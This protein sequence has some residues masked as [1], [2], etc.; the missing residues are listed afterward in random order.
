LATIGWV[1]L[2]LVLNQPSRAVVFSLLYL[3]EKMNITDKEVQSVIEV[4]Y[5]FLLMKA[6]RLMLALITVACVRIHSAACEDREKISD[7]YS[8]THQNGT[9]NSL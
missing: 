1:L 5:F 6:L 3:I 8:L 7:I 2:A 9:K 4:T